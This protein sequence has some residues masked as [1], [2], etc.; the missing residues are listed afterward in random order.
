MKPPLNRRRKVMGRTKIVKMQF[1]M[2]NK[3][4]VATYQRLEE[5]A[6]RSYRR[7]RGNQASYLASLMLGTR[8]YQGLRDAGLTERPHFPPEIDER[9]ANITARLKELNGRIDELLVP[10]QK[11]APIL[12]LVPTNSQNSPKQSA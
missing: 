4:D 10:E 1:D 9:L 5:S 7:G 6:R 3:Y 8:P 11:R 2:N 12:R